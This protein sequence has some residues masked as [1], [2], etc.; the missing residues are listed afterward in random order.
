LLEYISLSWG[1]TNIRR[2][3]GE[4]MKHLLVAASFA[5][6]LLSVAANGQCPAYTHKADVIAGTPG[7]MQDGWCVYAKEGT[8]GLFKTN[9]RSFGEAV[10]TGTSSDRPTSMDVSPDGQW[11][12]YLN[13]DNNVYLVKSSG[14][15][16]TRVP[17]VYFNVASLGLTWTGFYRNS[18]NGLEIF[19]PDFNWAGKAY[20]CA[21]PVDLSGA[22]PTFGTARTILESQSPNDAQ[23]QYTLWIQQGSCSVWG[24]QVF[25]LFQFA[26]GNLLNGFATIP[27][28]GA[29]KAMYANL[30]QFSQAVSINYYG[31][32]ETMSHDGQYCASNSA[33][34]GDSC[35]PN[36]EVLPA[37]MD[38][39]GPYITKFMRQG[40]DPV[41]A[42][43]AQIMDAR[44]GRSINW[45]P[46]SPLN[47]R[48]GTF[49]EVDFNEWNFSNDNNYLVGDVKGSGIAGFGLSYGVWVV[50]WPNNTWTQ[51]TPATTAI[52]YR[53][54]ALFFTS[55]GVVPG[56]PSMHS[57]LPAGR[58]ALLCA[59]PAGRQVLL[60]RGVTRLSVF[61]AR[62]RM[63]WTYQR[64]NASSEASVVL[65]ANAGNGLFSTSLK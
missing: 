1:A 28:A 5:V 13:S 42:I 41:V 15:T 46:A 6:A 4:W 22:T 58:Q 18:P 43:D 26:G 20:L 19:Y 17:L 52:H 50:Y 37:A 63:V 24:D 31:C 14:G 60:P 11:I 27:S 59:G 55:V 53:E 38:H 56:A 54:P 45:C 64:L 12:V 61:D 33:L 3:K 65:P 44:F 29:G 51:I 34:V 9:V 62:G 10:V 32:G 16:R 47:Y 36:K 39:K 7:A 49:D 8:N 25:A 57:R 23:R 21:I 2:H 48:Q 30:Y 35:V 40:T